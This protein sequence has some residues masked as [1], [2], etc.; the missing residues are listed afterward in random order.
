[1][2]MAMLRKVNNGELLHEITA[3]G[4]GRPHADDQRPSGK[5]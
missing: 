1:M 3:L 5:S 4:H 2:A